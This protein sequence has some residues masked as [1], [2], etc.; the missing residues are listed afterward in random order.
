LL[1][2]VNIATLLA[3]CINLLL[4]RPGSGIRLVETYGVSAGTAEVKPTKQTDFLESPALLGLQ[5]HRTSSKEGIALII[6]RLSRFSL[7]RCVLLGA[8][9]VR[10]VAQRLPRAPQSTGK[11]DA[12]PRFG[13]TM[14]TWRIPS[15]L[16]LIS[17]I[18]LP[19][20]L[21]TAFQDPL[22]AKPQLSCI[23]SISALSFA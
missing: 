11:T 22:T 20:D 9:S 18:W 17:L 10:F 6:C 19:H 1:S 23:K 15:S 16:S 2:A 12:S 13:G 8:I 7:S 14:M 3:C 5:F 4:I 21:C